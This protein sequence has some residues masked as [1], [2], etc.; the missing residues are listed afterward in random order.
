MLGGGRTG[1]KDLDEGGRR[2]VGKLVLRN[3]RDDVDQRRTRCGNRLGDL[4]DMHF[5]DARHEHGV[6]FDDRTELGNPP[7]SGELVCDKDFRGFDSAQAPPLITDLRANERENCRID[8]VDRHGDGQHARRDEAFRFM[9]QQQ[10][11]GRQAI[12]QIWETPVDKLECSKGVIGRERVTRPRYPDNGNRRAEF[13]RAFDD[14]GG[15]SRVHQCAADTRPVLPRVE[16]ACAEPALDITRRADGQM[17]PPGALT[18]VRSQVEARVPALQSIDSVVRGE[19]CFMRGAHL[20]HEFK[21]AVA[22][23]RDA[24]VTAAVASERTFC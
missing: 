24:R 13:K 5:V 18:P 9:R 21:K 11:V 16:L 7:D 17:Q 20:A 8:G 1:I 3:E 19:P 15:L 22:V 23:D 2:D 12:D 6:D 10:A 14:T 4:T